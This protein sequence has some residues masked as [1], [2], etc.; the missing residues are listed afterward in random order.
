MDN[1][2]QNKHTNQDIGKSEEENIEAHD[3]PIKWFVSFSNMRVIEKKERSQEDDLPVPSESLHII[4][5][6]ILH[7]E[8]GNR[9]NNNQYD[10]QNVL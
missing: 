8:F 7:K 1:Q 9:D 6:E 2:E 3:K 5:R 10:S 4:R